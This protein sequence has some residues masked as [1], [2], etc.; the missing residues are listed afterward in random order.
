MEIRKSQHLVPDIL[1]TGLDVV[2]CGTA[3]GKESY[4]QRAYYAHPGN[5]FW[6]TLHRTGLTPRLMTPHEYTDLP[7]YG[8][9]VTDLCKTAYGNDDELSATDFDVTATREKILA[10]AP[11]ILAFTSKNAC[12]IFLEK[13]LKD[14]PYGKQAE[15]VGKTILHALPSPSGQ[16]RRY[17]DITHWQAVADAAK[18]AHKKGAA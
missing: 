14:I 12:S 1:P 2:F 18:H 6:R 9:G 5:V 10:S 13:K 3:L 11:R 17:W 4:R 8:I 15:Q 7:R 16:G